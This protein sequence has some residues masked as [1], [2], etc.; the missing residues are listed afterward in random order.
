MTS[1]K[2]PISCHSPCVD[3]RGMVRGTTWA[4]PVIGF[5]YAKRNMRSGRP[6]LF[7]FHQTDEHSPKTDEHGAR[8]TIRIDLPAFGCMQC[9]RIPLNRSYDNNLVCRECQ[10]QSLTERRLASASKPLPICAVDRHKTM[11][12][13]L[14]HCSTVCGSVTQIMSVSVGSFRCIVYG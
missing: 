3:V 5:N 2:F 6:V 13:V 9:C 7:C 10:R 12:A 4:F 11:F 14:L 1:T 8:H